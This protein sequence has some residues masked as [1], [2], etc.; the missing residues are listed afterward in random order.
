MDFIRLCLCF[1]F[2][3]QGR[4]VLN[5][6]AGGFFNFLLY[7]FVCFFRPKSYNSKTEYIPTWSFFVCILLTEQFLSL[8][9]FKK[10]NGDDSLERALQARGAVL[11]IRI[12][13]I[14]M[15][16]GLPDSLVRDTDP[17][18]VI[19]SSSKN[20]KKIIDSC[21][22]LCLLYDFLSLKNDVNV[23]SKRN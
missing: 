12:R 14:H 20:S 18:P 15:L 7:F 5:S 16:L 1:T 3:F 17:D 9:Y 19:L 4:K 22:V 10:K 6:W 2:W 21:T 13:K 8:N 11:R 23:P